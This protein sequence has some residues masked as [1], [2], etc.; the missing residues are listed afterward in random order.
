MTE[1][2][3]VEPLAAPPNVTVRVPGSRSFTNRAL[4]AAALADGTS[5]I[6]GALAADDTEAMVD[7]WPACGIAGGGRPG[8][9]DHRGGGHRRAPRPR[10]AR[11]GRPPV[12]HDEPVPA[13][14]AGPR[15]RSLP[16]RRA[17]AAARPA[18]GQ[19]RST[20]CGSS[21]AEVLEE[22]AAGHLPVTV[23]GP[24]LGGAVEVPGRRVEP[25]PVRPAA[26]RAG[27]AARACGS[28]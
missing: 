17:R 19:H 1:P 25:V 21:G 11:A 18:D 4:V 6:E 10:A 5:R 14:P 13:A 3:E 24:V 9:G 26:G 7:T 16:A 12:R 15:P 22:G 2:H 27:D 20:R 23:G 28:R 8:G